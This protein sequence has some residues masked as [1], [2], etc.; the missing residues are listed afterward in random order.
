VSA[1]PE[2]PRRRLVRLVAVPAALFLV[3][4]ATVF[5]LAQLHPAKPEVAAASGPVKVGDAVA[6]KMTF[7]KACAGCHGAGGKAGGIGPKL[8]GLEI[9]LAQAKAQIDAGGG[10]M[11][12][13]LVT[14]TDEDNV[15]AYLDTIL[16]K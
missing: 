2:S 11:P 8:V 16:G 13:K 10:A 3:V 15:L 6:G 7:E 1:T 9:T 12:P 5:T 14:G 4:S